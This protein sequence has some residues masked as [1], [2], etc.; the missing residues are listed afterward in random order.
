M[1][2]C[3][4]NNSES[5]RICTDLFSN[6]MN[7]RDSEQYNASE[8]V[9]MLDE[10]HNSMCALHCF[11]PCLR[12]NFLYASLLHNR[13]D[14]VTLLLSDKRY[15]RNS[16]STCKYSPSA[17]RSAIEDRKVETLLC[18]GSPLTL[19]NRRKLHDVIFE[20]LNAAIEYTFV[21]DELDQFKALLM[22]HKNLDVER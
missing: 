3:W 18:R 5:K 9:H 12:G 8:L 7:K 4:D 11:R 21:I 1:H 17:V 22:L 13:S 6:L 10:V 20:D 16:T 2:T 14:V 19:A 15:K